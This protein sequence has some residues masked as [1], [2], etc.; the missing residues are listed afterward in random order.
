MF[1]INPRMSPLQ[2]RKQLLMAESE[3]NRAQLA[4]EWAAVTTGVRTFI[5]RAKSFTSI[6]SAATLLVTSLVA[7][8]RTQSAPADEKPSWWQIFLNGAGMIS[9]L[10]L[11]LRAKGHAQKD[12]EP[13]SRA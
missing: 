7:F 12:E 4:E 11:A 8:R 13:Q 3:L 9:T 2:L 10:W 6:F 1:G 5:S